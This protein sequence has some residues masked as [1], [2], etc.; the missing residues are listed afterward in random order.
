MQDPDVRGTAN[1]HG[2]LRAGAERVTE[3]ATDRLQSEADIRKDELVDQAHEASGALEGAA[4]ELPERAPTWLK[5]ALEQGA[6]AVGDL[7]SAA[8]QKDTA[9]L[10]RDVQ[11]FARQSPEGFLAGCALLG[12]AASRVFKAGAGR[13]SGSPSPGMG[14]R[15]AAGRP[16][17]TFYE[18][19]N[20][21][22]LM[23]VTDGG[24][25]P[26]AVSPQAVGTS[27]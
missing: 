12:F 7:A 24:G 18:G 5:S 8:E 3:A 13:S 14:D 1:L 23:S 10:L 27:L 2:E 15:L 22:P 4:R 19:T 6:K 17:P 21:A 20:A 25:T 26:S 16:N 11:R 9:E